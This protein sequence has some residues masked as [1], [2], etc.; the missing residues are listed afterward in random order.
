MLVGEDNSFIYNRVMQQSEAAA[1]IEERMEEYRTRINVE[2][3][4]YSEQLLTEAREQYGAS[5]EA[6]VQVFTDILLRGGKRM[7]GTLVLI[8]YEMA[9]G[10]DRALANRAALIMELLHTQL[11]LIDDVQDH[12]RVRRGGP[13][14]HILLEQH[15]GREK[16]R[17]DGV[18][19]SESIA[20]NA[21]LIGEQVAYRELAIL[22]AND[23]LK[24]EALHLISSAMLHT[25]HGQINDV[26][27]EVRND[28]SEKEVLE[29]LEWKTAKYSVTLPLQLGALLA[30]AD[31]VDA[32]PLEAYGENLG[33]AYQLSDDILGTFGAESKTGKSVRDDIA[34][35]KMTLLI[36]RALST[37]NQAQR[38]VI[39]RALGQQTV[40]DADFETCRTAVSDSGALEYTKQKIIALSA[41]AN[42]ALGQLPVEWRD[43]RQYE[44]L[45]YLSRVAIDRSR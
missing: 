6:A 7:R 2:I 15:H 8:A 1:Q 33:L 31:P 13:S 39:M 32:A 17:G 25:V 30:G 23:T 19:F 21:S 11:L 44:M 34:Q 18:H 9:G 16:F 3:A 38:A 26:F 28:V 37:G 27:N 24:L 5:S 14:A 45:G 41:Q 4:R 43:A 35:G 22:P 36:A 20:I 10:E 12:S 29:A 42:E 40:S